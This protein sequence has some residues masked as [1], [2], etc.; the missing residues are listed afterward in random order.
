MTELQSRCNALAA[1]QAVK[2]ELLPVEVL[3]QAQLLEDAPGGF[4]SALQMDG[5]VA[6]WS[7]SWMMTKKTNQ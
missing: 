5:R 7:S 6:G 1:N 2:L 3:A 4:R